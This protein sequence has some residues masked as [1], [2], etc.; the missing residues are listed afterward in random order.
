MLKWIWQIGYLLSCGLFT[1]AVAG[2]IVA[3]TRKR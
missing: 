3:V 1:F 2:V